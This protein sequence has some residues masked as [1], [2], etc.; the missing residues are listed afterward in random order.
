MIPA[1][2]DA[3]AQST[4]A[5]YVYLCRLFCHYTGLALGQNQYTACQADCRGDP[6]QET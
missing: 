2:P 4:A 1:H 3:Q 5:E 6:G